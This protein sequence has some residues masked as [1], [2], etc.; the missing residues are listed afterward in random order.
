MAK[1]KSI[2][3]EKQERDVMNDMVERR[4]LADNES[5]AHRRLLRAG[6]REYGYENGSYSKSRLTWI[7]SQMAWSFGLVALLWFGVTMLA[8]VRF[9]I[10]GYGLAF[11]SLGCAGLYHLLDRHEPAI[12]KTLFQRSEEAEA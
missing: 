5:E 10:I 7:A 11:A 12:S 2:R 4:G 3:L 9:R 1:S 8:P 6:M